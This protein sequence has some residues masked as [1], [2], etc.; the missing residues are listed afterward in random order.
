MTLDPITLALL[1]AI[2]AVSTACA[3]LYRDLRSERAKLAKATELIFALLQ[4][5]REERGER[6]PP[7]VTNDPHDPSAFDEAQAHASREV[8]GGVRE[9]V[10]RYLA[11]D[12][13]PPVPHRV[14]DTTRKIRTDDRACPHCG[15]LD[16]VHFS[17][18]VAPRK[19]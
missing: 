6:A 7:T 14:P 4:Q 11:G 15:L 9:L 2:G 10:D 13:T 17:D 12:S 1:S 5:R 19:P 3:A 16:G 8:N 18:C